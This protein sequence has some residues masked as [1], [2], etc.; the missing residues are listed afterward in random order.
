MM[1]ALLLHS[2]FTSLANYLTVTEETL[3]FETLLLR[4][5]ILFNEDIT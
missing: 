2:L 5:T 3:L 4:K 1:Q